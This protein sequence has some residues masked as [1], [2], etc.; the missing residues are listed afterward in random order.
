MIDRMLCRCRGLLSVVLV[1][2]TPAAIADEALMAASTA[3]CEHLMH[4]MS[5]DLAELP[6]DQ[7]AFFMQALE[8]ACHSFSVQ[9]LDM[10]EALTSS[11]RRLYLACTDS[12]I[13]SSC[14]EIDISGAE[15][16]ACERF[17]SAMEQRG[18]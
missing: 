13:R 5:E 18:G 9:G 6:E 1:I 4:C 15:T 7:R 11:E 12:L 10:D 17:N 3:A 16:P 2:S 8:G 14:A